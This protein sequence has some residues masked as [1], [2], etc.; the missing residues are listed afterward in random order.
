MDGSIDTNNARY[1][2]Y[3][4]RFF[5]AEFSGTA[6]LLLGG[7]SLVI[8]MFGAGSAAA[9]LIPSVKVRQSITGFLFGCI[10]AAIAISP[11]GKLSGAHVNPAVTVVFWL[12]RKLEGR[13]AI[14]YV[15]AQLAGA[16]AGCVP[17]LLWGEMGRGLNFGA[18]T[19][20]V[21]YTVPE[22]LLGEVITTFALVFM[23][24]VFI[25]F[26]K[27]RPF[28]PFMVPFLYGLMVPLEADISGI[29]TNP[30]RSFGPSVV[31][32][33]WD[34]WWIY[35]IGPLIGALLAAAIGYRL[36]RRIAIAKLYHFDAQSESDELLKK[37]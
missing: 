27:I 35:W 21:A 3:R 26:R 13:L 32:G 37:A 2:K 34:A 12:L 31:S 5:F 24:M 25:A 23:L 8:F 16:V 7:L 28:T 36:A 9:E 22:A 20:G 30:A 33:V 19:P 10:G 1:L 4:I 29:S 14:T 15:S 18:T 6:L 11:I 17:L